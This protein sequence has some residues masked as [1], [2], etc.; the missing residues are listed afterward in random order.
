MMAAFCRS[1]GSSYTR[2]VAWAPPSGVAG[3]RCAVHN[4]RRR[5]HNTQ[6][7]AYRGS[8]P[9]HPNADAW[10][11]DRER[12]ILSR[13]IAG[14][15][16]SVPL[17]SPVDRYLLPA[18]AGRRA[19]RLPPRR[20]TSQANQPTADCLQL[21]RRA[22][23]PLCGRGRTLASAHLRITNHLGFELDENGVP[24]LFRWGRHRLV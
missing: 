5:D 2:L 19:L 12:Q 6:R 18:V 17:W 7:I 1:F 20:V 13:L 11:W 23:S 3:S 10:L 15:N 24:S 21:V 16:N 9:G 4:R 14:G 22:R 8:E